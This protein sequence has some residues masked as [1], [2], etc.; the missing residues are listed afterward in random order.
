MGKW[1]AEA[2]Q[3][4]SEK[5]KQTG[6]NN[7][8]MQPLTKEQ[9]EKRRSVS[10]KYWS[11]LENRE[12]F[13]RLMKQVVKENPDSYSKSNVSGRCKLYEISDSSGKL[14]KVKG[15]WE[16]KVAAYLNSKNIKWTNDI[17]P[18]PYKWN[19]SWHLYFPDFYLTEHKIFIE[20]KG[21]QTD[22]DL[23][24]WKSLSNL[25]VLKKSDI[26]S[27]ADGRAGALSGLI[28]C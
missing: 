26:L 15:T 5:C 10:N 16:L 21:Y 9:L 13:S 20:V 28:S 23:A 12:K 2:K 6:C 18:I 22:R 4:W 7:T 11:S 1:S 27:L 24:K 14:V 8:N 19:N 17:E 3:R 25:I